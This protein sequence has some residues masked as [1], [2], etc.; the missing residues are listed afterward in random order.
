[1]YSS[2]KDIS[3]CH[4]SSPQEH[5]HQ[6]KDSDHSHV[7]SHIKRHL[8]S[9]VQFWVPQ[10]MRD[11]DILEWVQQRASKMMKGL[12]HLTYEEM[13]RQVGLCSLQ[14][15]KHWY[16][17]EYLIRVQKEVGARLLSVMTSEGQEAKGINQNTEHS[18][19]MKLLSMKVV[20]R[21]YRLPRKVRGSPSLEIFKCQ[22]NTVLVNC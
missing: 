18:V 17:Y 1:M 21:W 22:L 9:C 14:R 10:A 13:M 5:C 7:F 12:K 8:E 19:R 20:K 11:I 6:V 4:L 15:R 3:F 2:H 16:V